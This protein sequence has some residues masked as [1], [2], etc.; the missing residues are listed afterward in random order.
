MAIAGFW[1]VKFGAVMLLGLG[2]ACAAL[3]GPLDPPAGPIAS[4]GKT[5]TEVEPRIAINSTN[6][7]GDGATQFIISAP[8]SYYL[9]GNITGA[10]SKYCIRVNAANVSID[11]NGFT[12]TGVAS[13]YAGIFLS[14]A[15]AR[16]SVRNGTI[17][18]FGFDGI[19]GG[20]CANARFADLTLS[21]NGIG[22]SNR[23]GLRAGGSAIITNCTASSNTGGGISFNDGC[24]VTNCTASFNSGSGFNG[25][26]SCTIR[27][28]AVIGSG[29]SAF[30]V[31][32]ACTI[33]RCTASG[34]A[35][36]SGFFVGVGSRVNGCTATNF[37]T[38]FTAASRG[39]FTNCTGSGCS[40]AAF[41]PGDFAQLTACAA[42][43]SS[44]GINAGSNAVLRDCVATDN[45]GDNI[46][47]GLRSRLINCTATGSVSGQGINLAGIASS[48]EGCTASGNAGNGIYAPARATITNC[49]ARD[50]GVN[51][52]RISGSGSVSKCYVANNV[53]CGILAETGSVDI[54]DNEIA[55][56]TSSG[57]SAIRVS[58]GSGHR[59][60]G[61]TVS[62]NYRG[63]EVLS[64]GNLMVRNFSNLAGAGGSYVIA[65]GNNWGPI[66]AVAGD[67]S[68]VANGT[69]PMANYSR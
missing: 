23:Y 54:R 44:V 19:D 42:Y 58:S 28:C 55:D 51:G 5:M 26:A 30:V 21:G 46:A 53:G 68:T 22:Q 52:I 34:S 13:S 48:V 1:S 65:A 9:T 33:E 62:N 2:V 17:T 4:T 36:G 57:V 39:S 24:T 18:G 12:I 29:A 66:V 60:E 31:G 41:A 59:I 14:N 64:S 6:T 16:V 38:G 25:G 61:N 35:T 56:H 3:G 63:I 15:S 43:Q 45:S 27:E 47:V 11:L 7:P 69:H 67:L 50:N 37:S 49:T 40:S 32:N 8:G 10:N 20:F